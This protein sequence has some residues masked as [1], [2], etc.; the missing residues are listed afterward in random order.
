MDQ[1]ADFRIIQISLSF[2]SEMPVQLAGA[3][4]PPIRVRQLR[5]PS[6]PKID[7]RAISYH[8]TEYFLKAAGESEPDGDGVR[9]VVYGFADGRNFPEHDL[10]HAQQ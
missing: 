7:V 10:A 3:F 8:V 1:P 9:N 6:E 4:E 5:P 2:D